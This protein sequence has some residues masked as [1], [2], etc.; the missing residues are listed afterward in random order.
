[1]RPAFA[2]VVYK[3]GRGRATT[4]SFVFLLLLPFFVSLGPMLVM[5]MAHGLWDDTFGLALLAVAFAALVALVLI[6]L[7]YSIRARIELGN[8]A[9]RTTLPCGRGP[10][11]LLRY[12]RHDVPYENIAA[13]ETRCEVYGGAFAPV[14]LRG[15]SVLTRDG[16]AVPLGMVN[17]ANVDPAFPL[18]DIAAE[19]ARRAGVCVLDRGVVRR[20]VPRRMLGIT[21]SAAECAPVDADTV[22]VLNRRHRMAMLALVGAL[23]ALVGVGIA[24]DLVERDGEAAVQASAVVPTSKPAA[25]KR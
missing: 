14:M 23:A 1:M 2:C 20:S 15:F 5:R 24:S 11:P 17:E 6:E 13:V 21:A 18:T 16:V 8:A 4:F 12:A 19:I 25:R 10:S 9:L 7:L 3:A 22:A